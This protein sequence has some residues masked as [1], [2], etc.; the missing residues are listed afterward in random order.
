MSHCVKHVYVM[1][2]SLLMVS[3]SSL[4]ATY[5]TLVM[6]ISCTFKIGK[7]H[8]TTIMNLHDHFLSRQC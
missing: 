3:F 6:V 1:S 7:K 4:A 2:A 8:G 5:I